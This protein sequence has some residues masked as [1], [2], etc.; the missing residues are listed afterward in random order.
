MN[1]N[2]ADLLLAD[3]AGGKDLACQQSRVVG[4]PMILM[5]NLVYPRYRNRLQWLV[6]V[7]SHK[8]ARRGTKGKGNAINSSRSGNREQP[9]DFLGIS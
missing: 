7:L 5:V 6:H 9:L 4:H 2:V 1:Q 8:F 3:M